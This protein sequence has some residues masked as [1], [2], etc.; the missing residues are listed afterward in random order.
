MEG[1]HSH[2]NKRVK[3]GSKSWRFIIAIKAEQTSKELEMKQSLEL[4]LCYRS[5]FNEAA[6][7]KRT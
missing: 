6:E 1:W 5:L 4:S 3:Q 2:M 7:E